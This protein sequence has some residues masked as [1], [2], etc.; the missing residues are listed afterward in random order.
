MPAVTT[1]TG[2]LLA[3]VLGAPLGA[4]LNRLAYRLPRGEP[5]TG[6]GPRGARPFP[7]VE[8]ATAVLLALVV[9][10]QGA[11]RDA[12]LG[13]VLVALLVPIALIDLDHRVIPNKLT[14]AGSVAALALV[15][16]TAPGDLVEHVIAALG[17]GGFLLLAA[18]VYPSGMGMGDVKLAAMMGL[19]L[20]RAVIPAMIVALLAG[21][22]AGIVV[23]RRE[24]F[25]AGRKTGIPFGPFLALGGLVGVYAGDALLDWYVG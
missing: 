8:L 3:A 5:L 15:G 2:A 7:R 12:W 11:D 17:A 21:S 1:T 25:A 6:P 10:T 16:L 20:G 22:I 13:L 24:G 18:V 14:G 23:M 9:V 19:F 4:L